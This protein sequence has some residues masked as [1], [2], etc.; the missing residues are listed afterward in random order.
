MQPSRTMVEGKLGI[1][2]IFAN[3]RREPVALLRRLASSG[4]DQRQL[5]RAAPIGSPIWGVIVKKLA[6]WGL[7]S[8]PRALKGATDAHIHADRQLFAL[9]IQGGV[10]FAQQNKQKEAT[11]VSGMSIEIDSEGKA[12]IITPRSK[13]GVLKPLAITIS[14]AKHLVDAL[15][16]MITQAEDAASKQQN[17]P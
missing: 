15:V 12:V 3:K 4:P 2:I 5:V 8:M 11:I 7:I 14:G 13:S 17:K 16:V 1:Q 9:A 10:A 6:V